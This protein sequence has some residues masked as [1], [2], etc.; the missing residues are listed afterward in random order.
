MSTNPNFDNTLRNIF[1]LSLGGD[2]FQTW[3][4]RYL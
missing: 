3:V 4:D 1:A 2:D